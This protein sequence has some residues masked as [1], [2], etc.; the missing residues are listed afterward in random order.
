MD[1]LLL[2]VSVALFQLYSRRADSKICTSRVHLS[3]IVFSVLFFELTKSERTSSFSL[4][5]LTPYSEVWVVYSVA[6]LEKVYECSTVFVKTPHSTVY[7]WF[8]FV[9]CAQYGH[10][11]VH[12]AAENGHT[13]TVAT[14][15]EHGARVDNKV[16]ALTSDSD[17]T[18][19]SDRLWSLTSG[20]DR[21]RAA[22]I[23][24]ERLWSFT[25]VFKRISVIT[26]CYDVQLFFRA[27]L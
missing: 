10:T 8:R 3:Q 6:S 21:S 15:L 11:A 22:L 26:R 2:S 13:D 17:L 1:L 25:S 12:Y 27:P 9:G 23:D 5:N 19:A 20:S 18:N 14:L 7:N 4:V 24:H 16:R